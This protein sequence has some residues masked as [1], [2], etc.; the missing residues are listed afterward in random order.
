MKPRIIIILLIGGLLLP[1]HALALECAKARQQ[2]DVTIC[3]DSALAA[4]NDRLLHTLA[5]AIRIIG[6]EDRAQSPGVWALRNDQNAWLAERAQCAADTD[7]LRAAMERRI[8]VLSFNPDKQAPAPSDRFVGAYAGLGGPVNLWVM[9]LTSGN[10]LVAVNS[11]GGRGGSVCDFSG[12]GKINR[13]G[14]LVVGKPTVKGGGGLF[15]DL[16]NNGIRIADIPE[17]RSASALNC[18]QHGTVIMEYRRKAR[19]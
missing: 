3:H 8:T 15:L 1:H 11:V 7:C 12:V 16:T 17:N 10:A 4:L 13:D 2:V 5:E 18:G 14:R 19:Q 6:G 9:G